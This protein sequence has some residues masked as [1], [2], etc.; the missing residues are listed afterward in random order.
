VIMD[1]PKLKI[2]ISRLRN[3]METNCIHIPI[4]SDFAPK[5]ALK[6][7]ISSFLLSLRN[8]SRTF[9]TM[10]FTG[11]T[12]DVRTDSANRGSFSGLGRA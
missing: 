11:L 2:R 12:F 8:T 9:F 3:K 1:F 5:A 6:K 7:R 10:L 4:P